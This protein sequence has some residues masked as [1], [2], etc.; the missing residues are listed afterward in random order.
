MYPKPEQELRL[1]RSLLT[2]CDLYNKLRTKK[3][4]AYRT[5]R[6]SLTRTDLRAAALFERRS[7][8]ELQLVHSQVVQNV[9]DRLYI[10]F[11]RFF[12]RVARFPKPKKPKRY[13]SMTFPQFGFS[14]ERSNHLQLFGIGSVR[15]FLHRPVL[16]KIKRL[17]I[18]RDAAEW[19]A[20]LVT[21]CEAPARPPFKTIKAGRIAGVDLGLRSFAVFDNANDLIYP[22]YLKES[23]PRIRRIQRRLSRKSVGSKRWRQVNYKLARLH[24]H[25]KR[26][27]E[28][29]QNKRVKE[30]F[31]KNDAIILERLNVEGMRKNRDLASSVSDASFGKFALK[32]LFKSVSL[33]K[34]LVFVDPWGT[35]QFCHNCLSWV[36]KNLS[37]VNHLCPKCG[38][39]TTRDLN[40]ARLIK[41]LGTLS[42]PPSDGGSSPAEPKP[43]PSLRGLVSQRDEAGSHS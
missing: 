25:I 30:I 21:E 3:I 1:K 38:A 36:P 31:E 16:G 12:E 18:K 7:N 4:E 29:W 37:E 41:W 8:I 14:L 9:A 24:L 13:L 43:L 6:I 39:K 40:S 17:V 5:T 10:A 2:L 34:Y 11:K 35:T 28:D 22:R 32:C 19:Y 42:S 26:Q 23:R 33:G 15:L 20:I 27:R